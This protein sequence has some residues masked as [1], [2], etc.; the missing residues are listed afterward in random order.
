[1]ALRHDVVLVEGAGGLLVPFNGNLFMSDIARSLG[2]PLLVV[3]GAALGTI[4]HTLLTLRCAANDGI[5]VLGVVVNCVSRRSGP[6]VRMN[7]GALK[8]WAGVPVLGAIPYLSKRDVA[9]I[10]RAVE[11]NVDLEPIL[12]Y[13]R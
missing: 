6:A 7:P 1:M 2:L 13:L 3:A 8:R 5:R 4:N 11:E 12:R 10:Q 9:N